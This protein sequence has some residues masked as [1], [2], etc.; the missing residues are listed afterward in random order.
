MQS[1]HQSPDCPVRR[2]IVETMRSLQTIAGEE[3]NERTLRHLPHR[4]GHPR[5]GE[6]LCERPAVPQELPEEATGKGT[7]C[8]QTATPNGTVCTSNVSVATA[9]PRLWISASRKT[10]K[11]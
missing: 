5:P 9:S 7:Q 10:G 8:N 3:T 4:A 2:S 11:S 1:R 6:V